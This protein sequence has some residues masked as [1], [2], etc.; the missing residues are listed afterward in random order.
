MSRAWEFWIDVGGTFTDLVARDPYGAVR[1]HKLLSSG[2]YRGRV[3]AGSTRRQIVSANRRDDPPGFFEG[4]EFS[5]FAPV[6]DG[7]AR[8]AGRVV[9]GFEPSAGRIILDEPLEEDPPPGATYTLDF[10]EES[11]VVGVRWL[12]GLKPTEEVGPCSVRLGTTRGTN[13]LLERLGAPTALA[14]TRGFADLLT[15]GS[16]DRPRLF[17]L[18]I[19]KA[20]PLHQAVVEI[21]ERIDADGAVVRP[22]DLDEVRRGLERVRR[23]GAESLA[24]CLLNA[25]RNPAHEELVESIAREVGFAHV[26]RSTQL[27]P[28]QRMTPRGDTAVVDA[29]LTPILREYVERIAARMPR[30]SLRLMTSAGSLVGAASF[31]GK[32][33]ILSGPAGGVVGACEAARRAGL[34]SAVAFDMGGTSTDVSRFSP[35]GQGEFERRYEMEL[36]DARTNAGVRVVAPMLW[37]ETV[38]AGGGS[39]CDFQ[40]GKIVVGPRSAGSR[41]GPA[42]YGQGGPLTVTDVNLFLGR[43]VEEAF[44]IPIDRDAVERRMREM[45]DRIESAQGRR[46]SPEA[47]A[48]GFLAV[49]NASM[50]GAIKRISIS[51]G[52][53]VRRDGLVSFGGAGGQHACALAAELGIE[54]IVQHPLAGVLSAYG[55]GAAEVRKFG[56]QHVGRRWDERLPEVLAGVFDAMRGRLSAELVAEGVDPDRILPPRRILEMRYAGQDATLSIAAPPDGDFPRSFEEEHRRRYGF[57][58]Q[59]RPIEVLSARMELGGAADR[60]APPRLESSNQPPAP[61]KWTRSY[62]A[63]RWL[64]APV[65]DRASLRAGQRFDGPAV[66]VEPASTIVV[67]PGWSARATEAGD[68]VLTRTGR[69][70]VVRAAAASPEADAIGLEL[71]NQR[72]ASIA[73]QMGVTLQKSAMS[74]NVKERLDFSCALFTASGR[75]V[76]NAPHIPVHLGAMGETIRCLLEDAPDLRPGEA[77]LTNDP[78]RG[79]SHLP[80]VTVVSPVFDESGRSLLFFTASRAHHAEIGGISPGSMPPFSKNLA[81]E[82]VLLSWLRVAEGDEAAE[83]ELRRRLTQAPYPSRAVEENVAD[84]HAQI[85]ANRLGARLLRELVERE[86]LEVVAA[87][88]EHVQRAAA[89][90]MRKALLKIPAGEHRFQD[91]MDDGSIVAV[92]IEVFHEGGRGRAVVDFAGTSPTASSNL[93]ANPAVVRAAVMYSFRCLIEE[94]IPINDGVLDPVEIRI[95]LGSMLHPIADADPS[96]RPAVGA[97]NVETSQRIV[98]VVLGALG[99]AAASQGTMNNFLFGRPASPG[100]PGF[101]YYETICGGAGAG[102]GF[103]GASAV[104]THMTNTRI[105]DPEVLE[106]RYPVRLRRFAIRRG[107]GGAGRHPGGDGVVREFEFREPVEAALVTNRRTTAPFGL[108]GGGDASPGRNTWIRR[109]GQERDLGPAAQFSVEAGDV[110]RIETPGGGGYGEPPAG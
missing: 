26:S 97:G 67:E 28:S 24:V 3:D 21:D 68:V 83:A 74:T 95:P 32:D 73:E 5:L 48:E 62:M 52:Y 65:F 98:D 103:D 105:T 85:A 58:Y 49:A 104:H 27:S 91:A 51:R 44:S 102:P 29:Y 61:L 110:V 31:A 10:G 9:A 20:A 87:Y 56:E 14:T 1:T 63:G 18:A 42:C 90:Q 92:R 81:E 93:N 80:D 36:R 37:I 77:H 54:T 60:P 19:R 11:P 72:F 34:A 30:A 41:P 88:M 82:G 25:Y 96:K 7:A 106:D 50:S 33:L 22:P 53:D 71:F 69:A 35:G 46:Y 75:L 59:G 79:G 39:I 64:D 2:V 66:V 55:I 23:G 12:L 57:V 16:Q 76:V 107:S 84:V 45:L 40:G 8:L 47:L 6:G 13:A 99:A 38:A 4:C 43:L 15:I 101:G 109:D 86:G 17:D 89:D 108:A 78:F 100:R 70:P 94:D